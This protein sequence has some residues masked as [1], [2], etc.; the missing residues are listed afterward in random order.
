MA[1]AERM[2]KAVPETVA[3]GIYIDDPKACGAWAARGFALQCVSFDGRMLANGARLVVEEA[4]GS[5]AARRR[6]R[7]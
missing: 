5:M 6:Q 2:A 7:K 4:R 3:L 1:A